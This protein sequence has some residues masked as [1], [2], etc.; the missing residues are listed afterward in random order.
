MVVCTQNKSTERASKNEFTGLGDNHGG[1]IS[2]LLPCSFCQEKSSCVHGVLREGSGTRALISTGSRDL[3]KPIKSCLLYP[4]IGTS[5]FF[6]PKNTQ[7]ILESPS[8]DLYPH[9][10]ENTLLGPTL[11]STWKSQT[12]AFNMIMPLMAGVLPAGLFF[13]SV[14]WNNSVTMAHVLKD[15]YKLTY[16]TYVCVRARTHTSMCVLGGIFNFRGCVRSTYT[17]SH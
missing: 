3:R 5:H 14:S 9:Q 15:F 13:V 8:L 1:H 2:S 12:L 6:F 7:V 17:S 4:S 11:S 10:L 16:I